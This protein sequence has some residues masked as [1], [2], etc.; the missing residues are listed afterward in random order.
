[1]DTLDAPATKADLTELRN[2]LKTDIALLRDE[3]VERMSEIETHLLKA[4]YTFAE[5]NQPRL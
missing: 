5:S 2:E 1:M 3:L 4:F